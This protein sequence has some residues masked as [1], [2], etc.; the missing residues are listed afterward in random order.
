[1]HTWLDQQK[2]ESGTD[3]SSPLKRVSLLVGCVCADAWS[4]KQEASKQH[5]V[6]MHMDWTA[7]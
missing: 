6:P 5:A 1:M 2:D 4:Q 7:K 3:A